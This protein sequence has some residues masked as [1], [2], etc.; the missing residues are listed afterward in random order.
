MIAID[1]T[2]PREIK[3]ILSLL[4][5]RLTEISIDAVDERSAPPDG[6]DEEFSEIWTE[7]LRESARADLNSAC[8]LLENTDFGVRKTLCEESAAFAAV[9]GFAAL[10]LAMRK[11]AL[12]EIPDA[13][14]ESGK[15]LSPDLPLGKRHAY[16]CYCAFGEIQSALCEI[17]SRG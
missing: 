1:L 16:A 10:R 5:R 11:Y 17:L 13:E 9:R 15:I 3:P 2:L 7:E 8:D 4:A 14:L 6:E 12:R